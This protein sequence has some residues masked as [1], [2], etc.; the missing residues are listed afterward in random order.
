AKAATVEVLGVVLHGAYDLVR[1]LEPLLAEDLGAWLGESDP[2]PAGSVVLG[3][4]AWISV[5]DAAVEP[6]VV[7]DV[8]Q[9]PVVLESGVEV[10]S[11][12]RLEGPLWAGANTHL[13]GGP[14]RA[15]A[16]TC[17]ARC[18]RLGTCRRSRGGCARRWRTPARGS[19]RK[20]F[21]RSPSACCPAGTSPWTT[22]S[23]PCSGASTTGPHAEKSL[24]RLPRQPGAR[25]LFSPSTPSRMA[26]TDQYR[27]V[28]KFEL[29]ELIGEGAMGA[30]WK[31]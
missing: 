25:T 24:A 3:D 2:I 17:S 7:F 14:I 6:G 12:T 29:H 10:R 9:G 8:R 21:S 19:R 1:V 11:G 30:V 4:P 23:E 27:R 31:A 20:A 13:L 26:R 5:H 16:P 28:G 15:S 22:R 18:A